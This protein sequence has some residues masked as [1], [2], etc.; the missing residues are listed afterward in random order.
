MDDATDEKIVAVIIKIRAA[1]AALKQEYEK[2]K[3]TLDDQ[4]TQLDVELLRRL[5]ER[6]ATQTKT[7]AGT[8]YIGE[9]MKVTIADEG[10]LHVFLEEEEDPFGWYQKR[11]KVE[12]L[13]EYMEQHEGGVPPGLS[14]FKERTINVRAS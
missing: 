6:G 2:A 1:L 11:I 9:D 8:A 10:A 14:I 3:K 5:N 12:R 13:R 4:R 7:N